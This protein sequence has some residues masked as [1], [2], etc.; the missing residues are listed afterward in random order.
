[1]L[2]DWRNRSWGMLAAGVA[3]GLTLGGAMTVGVLL[4]Q[5]SHSA[6][7]PGLERSQIESDG[8]ARHRQF[9]HRYRLGR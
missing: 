5:R 3:I 9:C 6:A 4:G 7:A 2:S 8:H 1:M